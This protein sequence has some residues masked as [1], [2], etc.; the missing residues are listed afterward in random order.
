MI[1]RVNGG[2]I[3]SFSSKS[4]NELSR[5]KVKNR[6]CYYA[7]LAGILLFSGVF[8]YS[9]ENVLL[10]VNTENASVARRVFNLIKWCFD[11]HIQVSI[12]RNKSSKHMHSYAL[13]IHEREKLECIFKG[14]KLIAKDSNFKSIIN[15]RIHKDLIKYDCC[16]K[17]FIRGAYLGG[18]SIAD[19]EKA[20]HFEFI[21]R[22]YLLSKDF[23]EL[24]SVFDLQPRVIMRKSNYVIY[25]KGSEYIVDLLNII[26][27]HKS[28]LQLENIRI[29]KEMRNNVNR[30]VNCETANLEKTVSA[31]INQIQNIEYIEKNM[32]LDKLPERL[33]EMAILRLKYKE[34]SLK[35][36]GDMLST[37]VGKSGVNHRLRKLQQIAAELKNKNL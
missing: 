23:C 26:G 8:K 19:P 36:L 14:L 1:N 20:Y 21:T 9:G 25:F 35:E 7:E 11:M 27:A 18:G 24:L 30:V 5:V 28:L 34:A 15:F 4:K 13:Y 31:S 32:G 10:K 16:Q 29:M 22:F 2:I 17:A 3:L 37:P 6:C 33:Q 12:R